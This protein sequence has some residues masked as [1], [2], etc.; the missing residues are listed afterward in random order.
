MIIEERTRDTRAK[1]RVE[2]PFRRDGGTFSRGSPG[3]LHIEP[4]ARG[5]QSNND[6]SGLQ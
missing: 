1:R 3:H 5:D 6:E 2:P 4:D